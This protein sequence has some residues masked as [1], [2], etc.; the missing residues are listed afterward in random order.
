MLGIHP[1]VSDQP[2]V[3]YQAKTPAPN[4]R[5]RHVLRTVHDSQLIRRPR[6]DPIEL[7]LGSLKR[8]ACARKQAEEEQDHDDIEQLVEEYPD[9]I[10]IMSKR[11]HRP[12]F[13]GVEEENGSKVGT[14]KP[15]SNMWAHERLDGIQW[16]KEPVHFGLG[17][18]GKPHNC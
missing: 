16:M 17:W 1:I 12:S 14:W 7:F 5:G 6:D 15:I 3:M 18:C 13:D 4:A 2:K 8:N 9:D 11:L 10:T